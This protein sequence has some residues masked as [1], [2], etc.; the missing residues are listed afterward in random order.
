MPNLFTQRNGWIGVDLGTT[1][2]KFVQLENRSGNRA[3]TAACSYSYEQAID[4]TDVHN[5]D[6]S[7]LEAALSSLEPHL[8]HLRDLF[9]GR[10]IAVC[11]SSPFVPIHCIELPTADDSEVASMIHNEI[12]AERDSLSDATIGYW[13]NK[14]ASASDASTLA[15]S[16]VAASE[17]L[18]NTISSWFWKCGYEPVIMDVQYCTMARS[19]FNSATPGTVSLAIDIGSNATTM[20]LCKDGAPLHARNLRNCGLRQMLFPIC[21][22]LG[23]TYLEAYML[24]TEFAIPT[25]GIRMTGP[26]RLIADLISIPLQRL[27]SELRKTTEFYQFR[28]RT[29]M[30][31]KIV[32]GGTAAAI[33]NIIPV[34]STQLGIPA[35]IW[36]FDRDGCRLAGHPT[37]VFA[38][39]ISMSSLIWE[40]VKC[41]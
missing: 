13:S 23:L 38:N 33:V 11:L 36:A 5:G 4:I 12:A 22:Y 26:Q 40:P 37:A 31:Q 30:P 18:T 7:S 3:A 6:L 20:V 25:D 19:A 34:L 27:L 17:D 41:T 8:S 21:E 39:A 15:I 24:L 14:L 29:Q 16:A 10:E 35:Q 32:L 1:S 28:M 9:I 2:A